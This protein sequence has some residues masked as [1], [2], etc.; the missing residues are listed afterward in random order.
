MYS[1]ITPIHE[2]KKYWAECFGNAPFLPTSRKEMDALGWDSCDIIIVTGDAY[3]DHP[4]F[5][6]AIIGRLL[7]AQG[8]RVGIIAQ[9]EWHNKDAFTQLGRPN[10][11]FGITAGNM[12][13]MINRYTADRKLRHDD[14]YTPN[15]EGGKRPD[16]ATLVY[17]QRCREAYKGVPLVLGGIEASLRRL[18]HYDYWSDKVRRSIL[19]DAKADILLFGNAE[20]ALVEVAHRLADGEEIGT[21]TNIRG[22]VVSLPAEPEGYKV[23]D[24]SRIEKPRKEAFIPPNP[25]AVEEQ[26]DTKAKTEE[27]EAKPI[28]IRPSRHDAATTAVRIPHFEKLNNDRI[29]YAHA[30]RIMHLET[31]PY[32]GRA[33]IQRHGDREL[34]V[35]QAPI[36]L[37]TEEMDY[38]FGLPYARVPHPK[39]GKAK[40]PA[41]DMI[42]TSVNIMRGCFGGCSFCSITE[43]EGRIIQNRSQESII[44]ELE[45]IRDKVPGFT[46]TISDLGGP[47]ANM[48]RLGCSD[49][50][51][52]ANCRRPS[53]VFPG[54]CNKLNTDHK[55]T[56]DLYRAARKVEGVKKVMIASGVRYDLAIESPEY[57]KELV[58]HHV[59]G[60]LKIAPEHTEKG[61]LNL[62]MKPGMGTYDRFKEM[63]EK[64]SAEAGKK[65][66]LIPYF[67]SAHP[68]TEDEDMLNLALWLK[69]NDFEC[70]QVQ[71]FYPSPMCNATSMYYSE[72]N[73]LKRV[74]YKQR[75]EVPVAKGERQRRLHK[76]L[77]RYHDPANW[78]LIREALISMGK[79]H[80]IGDKQ[81][82]LVPAEDNEALTPAQRRKSGRH[83][84]NRFATK[85]TKSQPGFEKMNGSGQKKPNNSRNSGNGGKPTGGRNG[86]PGGHGNSKPPAGGKPSAGRK[87]KRR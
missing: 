56:I 62:M 59:G 74:K 19:F 21:M 3:V 85:H 48:Y 1:N 76:A 32:S 8:F 16:R 44:N 38:V 50:K 36:P 41:Y 61:P 54:I 10:L 63:F 49:P 18:A 53:C 40:I 31:N 70:D 80:L 15:N 46:G 66:Y 5:G 67:I 27:P 60:Y 22:T 14:A 78:P 11:F 58:T 75:E 35:N 43:H 42:K 55:H 13:S 86:K 23:I 24:S 30:S 2:H 20:R 9:P 64:Y 6:M 29:L 39:Y 57:V 26:C 87:P 83:G 52:E 72:T 69:K 77:L 12:D 33:L 4:S 28:A 65:Q 7:E 47:T 17:S 25:Y 71:N 82:C 73:P 37:S 51:A 84:S 81:S 79:K 45:E 34:W 68:G